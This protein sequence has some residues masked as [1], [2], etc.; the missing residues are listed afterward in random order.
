MAITLDEKEMDEF[1]T[2]GHTLIFTTVDK[3]GYPHSTPLW[4]IYM[5]GA[6]YTRGRSPSQKAKNIERNPRV[7]ALVEDGE[8]WV[9]LRA[10]M[11]RGRAEVVDD[12][13]MIRTYNERLTEKYGPYRLQTTAKTAPVP[14]ATTRH[15]SRPVLIWKVVPK[16]KVASWHNRKLRGLENA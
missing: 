12:E 14:E 1:L 10:V 11:V 5:D 7:C 3:D 15:Y 6:I 16:K 2:K 13:D 9:D 4:F 8:R